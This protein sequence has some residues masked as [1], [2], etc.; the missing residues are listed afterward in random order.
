MFSIVRSFQ[1]GEGLLH[2]S[3]FMPLL[4]SMDTYLN[5]KLEACYWNYEESYQNVGR[6]ADFHQGKTHVKLTFL[7][8]K[9][10]EFIW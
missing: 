6:P 5:S 7:A 10:I 9:L 3:M 8:L 1:T 4:F 2:L